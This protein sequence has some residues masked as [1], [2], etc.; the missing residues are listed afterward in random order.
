MNEILNLAI[1]DM[2]NTEFDCS[3][4]RH[5]NF[6][7]HDIAI[8]KGAM[9]ELT[10]IAA[11]FKDGK[12]LMISDNK[13]FDAAGA[14]ALKL[15]K[16]AGFSVKQL[17]FDRGE[18]ILIPD[19]SVIGRVLEELDLDITLMVSVGSGTLNDTAKYV[20]S[21]TKIP[22]IIVCTAPSMDGYVA[23]GAP[24]I[25][26]GR[27]ISYPACL[28]YGVVGDTDIMKEAPMHMIHAGFGDVV[29]KITAL[30]DW[31]LAV[32][33]IN[34]YRCDTCVELVKRALEK[35][36]SNA[37]Q[38]K[39]RN[40]EA[41]LYLI[42]ALTLTGVAMGL[43]NVSR[44]ASGAEHML[45]HYWEMDFIAKD[46][47]PELHGIKVGVATPIIAEFFEELAD[48]L[49]EGTGALCPPRTEIE[50]LL[51]S[52][53]CPISPIEIGIDRELFLNSLLEGYEVRPRY[54]VMRFAKEH[55]RLE[56]IAHKITNRI[57]GDA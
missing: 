4:G 34:E 8:G 2:S 12:I 42:E 1:N 36:F 49:P 31:D 13:T 37:E 21:R 35:C 38:L 18:G 27:K 45:S 6:S 40:D 46:R 28:A 22:Y 7:I 51:K 41:T 44:P 53:G 57:Y 10:R 43:V 15:M 29:G 55:G 26:D 16:D 17:C 54:S 32:K 24:L 14:Q 3:C 33:E 23:D 48:I 52:A 25:C 19:E 30:S 5:H 50:A 39:E 20:S 9:K 11:P 56:E 47:F